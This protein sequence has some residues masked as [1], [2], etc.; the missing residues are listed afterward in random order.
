MIKNNLRHSCPSDQRL[1]SRLRG[2]SPGA[3]LLIGLFASTPFTANAQQNTAGGMEEVYVTAEKRVEPL[4]ETPVPVTVLDSDRLA[5]ENRVSIRDYFQEVPG[6]MDAASY[7]GQQR[8]SIRGIT[9]GFSGP[10][11]GITIDDI[12]Y[13][14]AVDVLDQERSPT[15][16]PS[17]LQSLEVLRGPQGTLYGANSMGGLIKYVTKDP[18]T[19]NF[20]GTI[21]AGTSAVYRGVGPGFDVR[22]ALN[23]PVT[24]SFAVRVSAYTHGE[25]GYIDNPRFH[26]DGVNA[27][28]NEGGRITALWRIWDDTSIR[29]AALYQRDDQHGS[30]E[31]VVAPGLGDLQQNFLSG[32]HAN[33][34]SLQA[35]SAVI[36]SRFAGID[37]MSATGFSSTHLNTTDDRSYSSLAKPA[38]AYYGTPTADLPYR[39]IFTQNE[40]SEELRFNGTIASR[41]DWLLGGFF[42]K[43]TQPSGEIGVY[44][45]AAD[46]TWITPGYYQYLPETPL[47]FQEKAVFGDLTFR[48]TD[49]FDI[50]I[51]GRANYDKTVVSDTLF[52][53]AYTL[54]LGKPSPIVSPGYQSSTNAVTYLATPR[55]KVTPDL[56]VYARFASGYRPGGGNYTG[57]VTTFP[58]TYAA[59]KTENY[60]LGLKGDFIDHRLSVDTS[61]YYI[62]WKDIQIT[63]VDP[64]SNLGYD[65][66]AS[67]AKS[68]GVELSATGRPAAGLAIGGWISYDKAVLTK[69]FPSTSDVYGAPGDRLPATPRYSGNLNAEQ[70]FHAWGN[71]NAFVR[72]E[73]SYIGNRVG[74]FQGLE[75]DGITP[76][77][78]QNIPG[79]TTIDLRAGFTTASD[80][81]AKLYVLNLADRRGIINGGIGYNP[82]DAYAI[83]RPRT[84][85]VTFSKSF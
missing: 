66:N 44:G 6:L 79:Y 74:L 84:I 71:T 62:D 61:I 77:P 80:W 64:I 2:N 4:Q 82:P 28:D 65:T 83:I 11:V 78:R 68:E 1:A 34:S 54:L 17:D 26:L 40:F 70:T 14:A 29:L 81:D 69:G 41:V 33:D 39:A 9:T 19:D 48:I 3:T 15:V 36:K 51:G 76:A 13:G 75:D 12:P 60:E 52:A 42:R 8:L 43:Q 67:G 63:V 53:G 38:Q 20:S 58:A 7:L 27:I 59:D 46:G 72:A 16:D 10:T 23:I 21:S 85:G 45:L 57:V 24:E 37:V 22:G 56:M 35:Y 5:D 31:I 25:P 73:L 18:T 49:Q 30:S 50:Q 32:T 47:Y 55:F